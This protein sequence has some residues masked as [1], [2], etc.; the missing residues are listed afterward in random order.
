MVRKTIN[1]A[2]ADRREETSRLFP[3]VNGS[4][5]AARTAVTG[6]LK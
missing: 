5:S 4:N 3:L 1:D 6:L 2:Q